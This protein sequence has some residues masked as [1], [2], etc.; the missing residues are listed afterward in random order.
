[1]NF[2][3][4]YILFAIFA[5]LLGVFGLTQF[6][7]LKSSRDKTAWV[8]RSLNDGKTPVRSEDIQTLEI[9]RPAGTPAKLV[10]YRSDDGWKLRDPEVRLDGYQVDRVIDQLIGARKEEKAD[11]SSDL[12]QFGLDKPSVTV[13]MTRKESDQQWTL[14]VGKESETGGAS[15]KVV[16]VLSSDQPKQPMA[17]KRSEIDS[18][19]KNVSDFRSKSLLAESAFDLTAVDL[20]APKHAALDLAKNAD[21]NEWHFV[22]PAYGAAEYEG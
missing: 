2:K 21:K 13:T 12:G 17:V 14:K 8:F 20:E 7:G 19:F 3:T 1:M 16:Y 22:K 15:D 18:V 4:T 6:M 9:D 10:F 5:V 11:V